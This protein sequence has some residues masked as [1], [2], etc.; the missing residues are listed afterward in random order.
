MRLKK[1][2]I[3]AT[4]CALVTIICCLYKPYSSNGSLNNNFNKQFIAY[5]PLASVKPVVY[6]NLNNGG[7]GK[8]RLIG[9]KGEIINNSDYPIEHLKLQGKGT[10]TCFDG[11]TYTP[12]LFDVTK[13]FFGAEFDP[14][15]VHVLMPGQFS[16]QFIL[17]DCGSG[18][19]IISSTMLVVSWKWVENPQIYRTPTIVMTQ[20]IDS[21]SSFFTVGLTLRNDEK[22]KITT[23]EKALR[24]KGVL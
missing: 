10:M 5:L 17:V 15:E 13:T 3:H 9:C 22:I 2:I 8:Y 1:A 6:L 20:T 11:N 4:C 21:T 19:N 16:S 14:N 18:S 24:G 12:K 23:M 7:C